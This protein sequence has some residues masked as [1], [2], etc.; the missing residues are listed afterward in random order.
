[1]FTFFLS[2]HCIFIFNVPVCSSR[3]ILNV[4]LL[5]QFALA[6]LCEKLKVHNEEALFSDPN[7]SGKTNKSGELKKCLLPQRLESHP[8]PPFT[9]D[10]VVARD[11]VTTANAPGAPSFIHHCVSLVH[12]RRWAD[13]AATIT[14]EAPS[15]GV[16]SCF[17]VN[18]R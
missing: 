13:D 1:M 15:A 18:V 4:P 8:C 17:T 2:I 10:G 12:C 3:F 9:M 14:Q 7:A 5:S 6:Q 11:M 16:I